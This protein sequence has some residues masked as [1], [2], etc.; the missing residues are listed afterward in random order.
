MRAGRKG[1]ARGSGEQQAAA[2][3]GH[4][5][6]GFASQ[7]SAMA[8]GFCPADEGGAA[9]TL[10]GCSGEG[11][12]EGR[13]NKRSFLGSRSAKPVKIHHRVPLPQDTLGWDFPPASLIKRQTLGPG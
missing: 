6:R 2:G 1:A 7:G 9:P 13:G 8:S 5:G 4:L 3:R 12:R 11:E 10:G